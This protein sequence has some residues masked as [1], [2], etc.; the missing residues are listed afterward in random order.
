MA[1]LERVLALDVE[2]AG[3]QLEH[4]LLVDRLARLVDEVDAL[5]VVRDHRDRAGVADELALGHLAV[6][7]VADRV[8]VDG[9]DLAAVDDLAR[10]PLE[11]HGGDS[12]PIASASTR[13]PASAARKN[14]GSSSAVRPIVVAGS[15]LAT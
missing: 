3:R 7:V 9:R 2:L 11:P 6:V 12:Y 1:R 10:D 13:P 4:L 14:V 5:A 15:P 8:L